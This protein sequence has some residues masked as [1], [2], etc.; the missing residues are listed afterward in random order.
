MDAE[1]RAIGSHKNARTLPRYAKRTVKQ[2]EEA[3]KKR[4]LSRTK[5]GELS[6]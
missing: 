4:R 1:L 5:P 2:V 6:K 3:Q